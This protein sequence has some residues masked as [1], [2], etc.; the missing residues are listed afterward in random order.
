[1]F[2]F[3]ASYTAVVLF[4]YFDVKNNHPNEQPLIRYWPIDSFEFGI[5]YVQIR[6]H[7]PSTPEVNGN[8]NS[9]GNGNGKADSGFFF[10]KNK[11][12][13]ILRPKNHP[14]SLKIGDFFKSKY[15]LKIVFNFCD[16]IV[17][18]LLFNLDGIVLELE[19]I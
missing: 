14:E 1:M 3:Q 13:F 10:M 19:I 6:G 8:G 15:F 16:V 5:P 2:H 12:S 7:F 4:A 18:P 9:I 11:W 17:S